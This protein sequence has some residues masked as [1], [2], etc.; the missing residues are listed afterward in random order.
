[1]C[2][3]ALSCWFLSRTVGYDGEET[4]YATWMH[5]KAWKVC[6]LFLG[7][8]SRRNFT[9]EKRVLD[10]ESVWKLISNFSSDWIQA[11]SIPSCG[12]L[13]EVSQPVFSAAYD[14]NGLVLDHHKSYNRSHHNESWWQTKRILGMVGWSVEWIMCL[15]NRWTP[16]TLYTSVYFISFVFTPLCFG[17]AIGS[18]QNSL[19]V[20]RELLSCLVS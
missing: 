5:C 3:S 8:V 16:C 11:S 18:I 1:M 20:V 4:M 2:A 9:M 6:Q 7:G 12:F 13:A 14:S 10:V 17:P 19:W 15:E